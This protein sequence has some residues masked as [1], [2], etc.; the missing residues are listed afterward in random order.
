MIPFARLRVM[1]VKPPR[2]PAKQPPLLLRG[3]AAA[4]GRRLSDKI[5]I[6]FHT[7]CDEEA[8]EIAERLLNQLDALIRR[9]PILPNGVDRRQPESLAALD[10]RLTN[11]LLWRLESE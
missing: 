2:L 5:R 3:H 1:A 10:E 9:P 4:R 7:A 6:A 8:F 11:L